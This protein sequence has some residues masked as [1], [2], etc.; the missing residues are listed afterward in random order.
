MTQYACFLRGVN[1]GNIRF[2]MADL[3]S[4]LSTLNL[5][6]VKTYL[7]TGNVS[8]SSLKPKTVLIE[9]L[10]NALSQAFSYNAKILLYEAN[11]LEDII[12]SC[13]FIQDKVHHRYIILVSDEKAIDQMLENQT[14]LDNTTERIARGKNV[15][16][17]QVPRGSSTTTAFA[18]LLTKSRFKTTITVRNIN[19]LEKM[20]R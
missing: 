5:K 12:Q 6:N 3:R 20:I 13:P 19:T 10:E 15:L 17:W 8:F 2:T 4:V 1:V 9:T 14:F 18:K 16:Y 11:M 7:Q